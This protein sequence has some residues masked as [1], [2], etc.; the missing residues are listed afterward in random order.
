MKSHR[1]QP[2]KPKTDPIFGVRSLAELGH[3]CQGKTHQIP[4]HQHPQERKRRQRYV[5]GLEDEVP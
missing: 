3:K 1:L 2:K 5:L 4:R